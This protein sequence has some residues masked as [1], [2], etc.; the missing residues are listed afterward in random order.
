M[1][2]VDFDKFDTLNI[3]DIEDVPGFGAWP[4][5]TY[6][7]K[8]ILAKKEVK[9]KDGPA[10]CIE[11]SFVLVATNE[12]QDP[13]QSEPVADSTTSILMN[14]ENKYGLANFKGIGQKVA[15]YFGCAGNVSSIVDTCQAV[16]CVVTL[17]AKEDKSG[18]VRN[19]I[20]EL[21]FG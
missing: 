17:S 1:S 15:A 5:G 9:F 14:L 19:D 8:L 10:P 18:V 3:D 21:V 6:T 4:A 7:A 12:L 2:S 11:A 13:T 16:D 20:R